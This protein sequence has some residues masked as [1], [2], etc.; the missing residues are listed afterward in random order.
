MQASRRGVYGFLPEAVGPWFWRRQEPPTGWSP[1]LKGRARALSKAVFPSA[2]S[3]HPGAGSGFGPWPAYLP[4]GTLR[5]H[6]RRRAPPRRVL[7]GRPTCRL[8]QANPE[9]LRKL[10]T[11]PGGLASPPQ[12]AFRPA[13]NKWLPPRAFLP[14]GTPLPVQPSGPSSPAGRPGTLLQAALM[15]HARAAGC[16]RAPARG[17][18]ACWLTISQRGWPQTRFT[19]PSM[20]WPG[21]SGPSIGCLPRVSTA[22]TPK[23]FY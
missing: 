16:M 19:T 13:A 18:L 23:S 1:P 21:P 5:S 2:P 11:T 22:V 4:S 3:S 7:W 15:D 17:M 12:P 8:H 10:R 9:R 6:R 14:P 20:S